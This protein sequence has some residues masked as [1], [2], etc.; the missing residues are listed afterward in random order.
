MKT[1]ISLSLVA[2]M[3]YFAFSSYA[4][5]WLIDQDLLARF[6]EKSRLFRRITPPFEVLTPTGRVVAGTRLGAALVFLALLVIA[7]VFWPSP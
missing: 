1:F 4:L 3:A 2:S 5:R 6:Q 7:M